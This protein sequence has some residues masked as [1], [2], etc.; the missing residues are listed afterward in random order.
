MQNVSLTPPTILIMFELTNANSGVRVCDAAL[1]ADAFAA[2]EM[3]SM[4]V[5]GQMVNG[6]MG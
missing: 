4:G 1:D 5:V 6:H 2:S 3:H